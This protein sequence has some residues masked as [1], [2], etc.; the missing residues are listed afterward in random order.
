MILQARQLAKRYRKGQVRALEGVSFDLAKGRT[1]GILGESGS[2]KSTLAKVVLGLVRPDAGEVLF[3]G[4]AESQGT[5]SAGFRRAVRAVF[6]DPYA[7][8]DPRMTLQDI[9]REPFLIR[10]DRPGPELDGSVE[11]LLGLVE[12]PARLAGKT[13]RQLSGGECQRAAIARAVSTEPEVIVCD[14]PVSS[15]DVLVQVQ[16]LNLLLKLQREKGLSYLFVS[17]DLRVVRH[18]SDEVIVMKDGCVRESGLRDA[19]FGDPK[20]EYTRLLLRDF[21]LK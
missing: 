13:P 15:L 4:A 5:R 8:L 6:Q 17:H 14:E 2:G 9:L 10:G 1:L 3:N 19:V 11:R 18:M 21:E 12:L 20:D 7:S 16:I